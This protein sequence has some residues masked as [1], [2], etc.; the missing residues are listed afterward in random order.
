MTHYKI[1]LDIE[2]L[3]LTKNDI[4]RLSNPNCC[5]VILFSRNFSSPEQICALC[6]EIK[7][8]KAP[9]LLVAVDHEGGRVQRFKRGFTRIPPMRVLGELWNNDKEYAQY[10]AEMIGVVIGKEL[11]DCGIDFSFTPVLDLDYGNSGVIGDRAL[12]S[13][14]HVVGDL[15]LSIMRGLRKSGSIAVGKH[16]PGH[17]F[18]RGDSHLQV[19][20][21]D[22]SYSEVLTRDI[23]PYINLIENGISAIMPAHI[24]FPSIDQYPV[25]FSQEWLQV[26]LRE[27]LGFKGVIFSDDLSME[28]ASNAGSIES[29]GD[30]AIDAGCDIVLVCN[31]PIGS[32]KLLSHFEKKN[33]TDS[34][35][36][37]RVDKLRGELETKVNAEVLTKSYTT[38]VNSIEELSWS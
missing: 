16:F 20:T 32:D 35:S 8:I 23:V 24:I 14:P 29:R 30:R 11:I 18:A 33:P 27:R 31:N 36:V 34:Q 26:I 1:M 5:G 22:R 37:K 2:G 9:S 17:G 6:R 19:V 25:G 7:Q 21:D 28:G 15:S 10:L 4:K 13:D 38:A 12:H 3:K